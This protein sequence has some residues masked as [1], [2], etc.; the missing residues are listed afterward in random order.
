MK[1][2]CLL[3]LVLVSCTVHPLKREPDGS[4]VWLGA[5]FFS[6]SSLESASWD[7]VNKVLAYHQASKDETVIPAKAVKSLTV[8]GMA[9]RTTGIVDSATR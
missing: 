8:M 3:P 2:A 1:L 7:S 9:D 6:K 5:S 4:V